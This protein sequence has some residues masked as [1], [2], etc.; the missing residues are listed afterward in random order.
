MVAAMV[1]MGFEESEQD[2]VLRATAAVIEY[3]ESGF[4]CEL[5]FLEIYLQ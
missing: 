3:Q 2:A 5:K 4:T 1:A